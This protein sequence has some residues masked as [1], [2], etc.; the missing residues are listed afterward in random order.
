MRWTKPFAYLKQIRHRPRDVVRAL[1]VL[2]VVG[3]VVVGGSAAAA[4]LIL[5]LPAVVPDPVPGA[6]AQTSFVYAADGS[7]LATFHAEHNRE[8]IKIKD[9][10]EHLLDAAVA[11]EDARFYEH[12]GLDV[13]AIGRA[14]WADI[15]ARDI[16]QGG[17]TITQQYVKNAYIER[18]KRTIFRKVRE[19]LL[20]SQV[21]RNFSKRAILEN[22]LNTVYLGKG[23]YGVEAASKTY[24]NKRAKDLNITEAA[25]LVG[26]I[27]S[28]HDYSPYENPQGAEARRQHVLDRMVTLHGRSGGRYGIDEAR[29]EH[30]RAVVPQVA[31]P[32]QEVFRFPWFVDAVRRD[33]IRRYEAAYGDGERMVFAGGLRIYTTLDPVAQE[34]GEQA[35]AKTLNRPNDPL[36]TL[37]A[38]EPD[39]GYVR[40]LVTGDPY[41]PAGFNA[42]TEGRGRPG[43]AFKTFGLVGALEEGVSPRRVYRAPSSIHINGWGNA[44][45]CVTNYGGRGFGSLSL[46][47]AT[48]ASVN[49]VYAQVA[50]QIGAAKIVDAAVRMGIKPTTLQGDEKNPAIVI[51]GL[52]KGV[53]T[54][55][56]ASGYATLGA[57]G[58]YR[59]P[60]LVTR[61]VDGNGEVLES[62]PAPG[63]QAVDPNVAH[64]VNQILEKVITGSEVGSRARIGRP[65]AAKTGTDQDFRNATFAGYTPDLAA[66]VMMGYRN[67][68]RPLLNL[69]GFSRVFGGSIPAI[70]WRDFMVKALADVPPSDFPEPGEIR[71]RNDQFRL[72]FRMRSPTAPSPTP[73]PSPSPS[74][75]PSPS[76][77]PSPSPEPSESPTV[78]P[79]LPE[80]SPS[81]SPSD[82]GPGPP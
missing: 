22:Y 37:V 67:E 50:T 8:L 40:A 28:P 6:A 80:E 31:P 35:V 47:S 82:D 34:A 52:T 55:E 54:L 19:A 75:L 44:C 11:A 38:I 13:K 57:G 68:L 7:L 74:P 5:P 78:V 58:V 79:T 2:L 65:A 81:P 56:M 46:E 23:A 1:L 41:V 33:L 70:I 76:P 16:V 73:S 29:A 66:V 18:P 60:K 43:S 27:P 4:F 42:A 20:A 62:G 21:E 39:T 36:A 63:V 61:V 45:S 10:P 26:L 69:H 12:S 17:S 14:L 30:A 9:M 53:S 3:P 64:T 15:R 71:R 48:V 72:P 24:F 49:T 59:Q 77:S 51:G 32:K 25:L